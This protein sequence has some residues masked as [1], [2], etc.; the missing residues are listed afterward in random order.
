MA[1][2]SRYPIQILANLIARRYTFL[3]FSA[4]L[5]VK[6]AVNLRTA[7]FSPHYLQA[8]GTTEPCV[9]LSIHTAIHISKSAD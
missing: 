8:F 7:K 5:A 9:N 2:T 4:Y 6:V 1:I 3:F